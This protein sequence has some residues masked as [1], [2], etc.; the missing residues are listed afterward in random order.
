MNVQTVVMLHGYLI[1]ICNFCLHIQSF[2]CAFSEKLIYWF[3]P[4]CLQ[5]TRV[6]YSLNVIGKM[7]RA[8]ELQKVLSTVL[9]FKVIFATLV[10]QVIVF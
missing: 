10:F 8:P 2:H 1:R 9:V 3:W 4:A 5:M 7:I 6:T